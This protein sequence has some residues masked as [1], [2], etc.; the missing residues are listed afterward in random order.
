MQRA[1]GCTC[2][3]AEIVDRNRSGWRSGWQGPNAV[4]AISSQRAPKRVT[5]ARSRSSNRNGYGDQRLGT[6]RPKLEL[7]GVCTDGDVVRPGRH[8]ALPDRPPGLQRHGGGDAARWHGALREQR[9][10]PADPVELGLRCVRLQQR[11]REASALKQE[12]DLV[13]AKRGRGEL[14][15]LDPLQDGHESGR[16]MARRPHE[17]R[18][19]RLFSAAL[20]RRHRPVL[21]FSDSRGLRAR[22]HRSERSCMGRHFC[23]AS[24]TSSAS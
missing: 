12:I 4:L 7:V 15:R 24:A 16:E 8:A 13:P 14:V 6:A 23:R 18:P 22:Y 2:R 1:L 17:A 19:N 10:R 20:C 11:A 3:P 5:G 21:Q 9:S